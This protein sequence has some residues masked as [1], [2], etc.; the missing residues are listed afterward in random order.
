MGGGSG[1]IGNIVDAVVLLVQFAI[2]IDHRSLVPFEGETI[3]LKMALF[4]AISTFGIRVAKRC[5]A[6]FALVVAVVTVA[7]VAIV[8]AICCRSKLRQAE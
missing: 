8:I 1:L 2:G 7:A 4:L 6:V 3:F 5:R